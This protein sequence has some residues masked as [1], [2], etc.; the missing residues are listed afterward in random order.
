MTPC[1]PLPFRIQVGETA[2]TRP[3]LVLVIS[4]LIAILTCVPWLRFRI[5]DE[6]EVLWV[7]QKGKAHDDK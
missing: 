5:E 2:A 4:V 3:V 7:P 1:L 6:A